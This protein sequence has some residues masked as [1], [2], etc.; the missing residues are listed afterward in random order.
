MARDPALILVEQQQAFQ[1]IK[2]QKYAVIRAVV[3][4]HVL[5]IGDGLFIIEKYTQEIQQG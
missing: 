5:Q 3:V 4:L 2:S 1:G